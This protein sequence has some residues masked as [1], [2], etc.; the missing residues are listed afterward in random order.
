MSSNYNGRPGLEVIVLNA[1]QIGG[2]AGTGGTGTATAVTSV[3]IGTTADAPAS[4][5]TGTF[6]V[7]SLLKRGMQ[8]WTSLLAKIPALVGGRMP[9]QADSPPLK[10]LIDTVSGTVMYVCEA[11]PQSATSSAVWRIKKISTAGSV[12]TV[13]Y[14]GTGAFDQ[15]ADNRASLGY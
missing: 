4:S 13:S 11:A 3:D 9:V 15:V 12:Q 7:I 8:N 10:T 2:G 5:D 1:D 14:A 6:S